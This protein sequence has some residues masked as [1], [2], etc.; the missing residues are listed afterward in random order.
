M[1]AARY[2][3]TMQTV[4]SVLIII[5]MLATLGVLALGIISIARGGDPHRSNKLMQS[6]ILFQGIALALLALFFLLVKH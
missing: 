2:M 1:P 5:A 4:L 3:M 6:R